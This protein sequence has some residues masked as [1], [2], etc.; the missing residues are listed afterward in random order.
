MLPKFPKFQPFVLKGPTIWRLRSLVAL[1]KS[2]VAVTAR[3]L[4]RGPLLASWSYELE[5][6]THLFRAQCGAAVR[7][8]SAGKVA[9]CRQAIDGLVFRLP[10]LRNVQILAET[11]APVPGQWFVAR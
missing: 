1:A 7:L 5:L 3:R 8:A 4:T 9:E 2:V 10:A 6:A 11:A